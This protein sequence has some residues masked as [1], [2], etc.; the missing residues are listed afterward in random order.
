VDNVREPLEADCEPKGFYCSMTC[1]QLM[2]AVI[3]VCRILCATLCHCVKN[4]V[5]FIRESFLLQM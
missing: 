4:V 3:T 5:I 1:Q 2:I